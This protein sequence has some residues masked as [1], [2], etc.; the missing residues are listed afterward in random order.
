M[1]A[2]V[3]AEPHEAVAGLEQREEHGLVGLGAGMGLDVGEV[4][5]EQPLGPVDGQLLGHVHIFAAAV[6]APAGIALGVFVGQ[7]RALGLQDGLGDDVLGGDELD[8]VLLAAELMLDRCGD[9]RV[10]F[11]QPP[12]EEMRRSAPL[13]RPRW[14]P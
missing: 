10:R 14:P 3:E 6:V 12:C 9:L 5:I 4:A 2:G 13:L 1:A 7:D 8:V 11:R